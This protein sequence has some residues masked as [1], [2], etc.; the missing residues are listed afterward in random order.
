MAL[1]MLYQAEA[2]IETVIHA[3]ITSCL[4]YCNSLLGG[5][6]QSSINRLQLVQNAAAR[7][8]TGTKKQEHITP[9]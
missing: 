7:L 5:V 9:V 4:D 2:V 8:Q 3:F 1:G 6:S